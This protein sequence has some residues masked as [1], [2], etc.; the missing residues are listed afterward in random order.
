MCTNNPDWLQWEINQG[1]R[2]IGLGADLIMVDTPMSSSFVSGFLKAGFCK[3][4][5]VNFEKRL[6]NRFTREQLKERFGLDSFDASAVIAR[7]A[8]LQDIAD[9]KRRPHHNSSPDDLLFREFIYAQE[10]ASFDTRK[11]LV[12]TLRGYAREQGRQVAFF[13]NASDLGTAN[14]GGHWIRA[15][16]FADIFDLF[17]YELNTEPMGMSSPEVLRYPRGKWAAYHKLAY[18]V[19]HRRSPSVIHASAMGRLVVDV[20]SK[21]KSE[22]TWMEVQS[23]EAYAANGAYIQYYIEPQAGNRRFLEKCWTGSARHAAFVQSRA[24]LYDGE[25]RSGSSL[26]LVFLMNERGRTIPAVFPSYL[27]FAQALI[28]GNFPFDVLFAGDGHYV[29]DRL[30]TKQLKPYKTILVPSP[31][32]PTDH[33]KRV[34]QE[35]ANAGGTI[36]C[37]EPE[38][39]GLARRSQSVRPITTPCLEGQF[40]HG[41]GTVLL[42]SGHVSNT[43][44]DDTGSNFFKTYDPNLRVQIGH[45]AE[46]L[47][48]VPIL[49]GQSGTHAIAF[50]IVDPEKKRLLVHM[51][52]YDI[53]YDKDKIRKQTGLVVN[54]ARTAF[55]PENVQ[56]QLYVPGEPTRTLDMSDSKGQLSISL[57]P[58]GV[59]ATVVISA[60]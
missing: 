52:N 42:L 11:R 30:T 31:I 35:F 6:H 19:Y 32:E 4:C 14:P 12:D 27:G 45:L 24:D 60:R 47:G 3:H 7:L 29:Q 34:I 57:P 33:Q 9:P 20:I 17:A 10:Q 48:L 16:M 50:L 18:A 44:T 53:D 25:L 38:K 40:S 55:L 56:A 54:L 49:S 37:Q 36:V 5:M 2:G 22:N 43:W 39:L 8:P 51:V 59:S 13:T 1:K 41:K 46:S 23:S 15:L 21:G 28:E 26:A 58:L